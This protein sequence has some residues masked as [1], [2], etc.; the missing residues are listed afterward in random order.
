[1]ESI[2]MDLSRYADVWLNVTLGV[3]IFFFPG[4][5]TQGIFFWMAI[6]HIWIYLFDQYRVLRCIPHCNYSNMTVDW[7]AT[8]MMS[9]PLGLLIVCAIFKGNCQTPYMCFEE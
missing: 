1:M 4:G 3:L 6:A 7:Y 8:W 5:L 2:P 9:I